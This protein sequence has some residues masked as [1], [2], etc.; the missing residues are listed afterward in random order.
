MVAQA[1]N[2]AASARFFMSGISLFRRASLT[3][4]ALCLALLFLM[5]AGLFSFPA[6][7][8]SVPQI[9]RGTTGQAKVTSDTTVTGQHPPPPTFFINDSSGSTVY[10]P[11]GPQAG[12]PTSWDVTAGGLVTVPKYAATGVYTFS[13]YAP[14]G[15][16]APNGTGPYRAV[17]GT[18]EVVDYPVSNN[19][20]PPP[21]PL[22][23]L[24]RHPL[25]L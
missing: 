21:S 1:A 12:D 14:N 16:Q 10:G 18:F 17:G 8:Q 11:A 19:L 25:Q 4:R 24:R 15:P 5:S 20:P 7:A 13:Y 3:C 23:L 22:L 9:Q 6:N 2:S